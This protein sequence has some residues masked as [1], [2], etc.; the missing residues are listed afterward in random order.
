MPC[1]NAPLLQ[2]YFHNMQSGYGTPSFTICISFR[3]CVCSP[4][5]RAQRTPPQTQAPPACIRK[6]EESTFGA[7]MRYIADR[8]VRLNVPV[9]RREGCNFQN[10]IAEKSLRNEH[11]G[12][13]AWAQSADIGKRRNCFFSVHRIANQITDADGSQQERKRI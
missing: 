3:A 10:R 1:L 13:E 5:D 9:G 4:Q 2:C 6:A 12:N 7:E 11:P 8:F